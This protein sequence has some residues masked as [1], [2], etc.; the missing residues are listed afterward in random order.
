MSARRPASHRLGWALGAPL[1]VFL[2][3]PIAVL[4]LSSGPA[5]VWHALRQ[6]HALAAMGLSLWTTAVSLACIVAFG[7]PLAWAL[8][9]S[10][11]TA[12]RVVETIVELPI[13]VPPAVVGV[14]LLEAWGR[15]GAFGPL[16]EV[17][18][19]SL[20]FTTAAVVVAQV[21]VAAP[22]YVQAAASAFRRVDDDLILVARTLGAGPRRAFAQV[23]LPAAAP[24]LAAGAALAWA[25]A[26]GEFGATL[27]FAG[28][29]P[30]RTQTMPLAIYSALESDLAIARALA[31]VLALVAFAVLL[32]LRF[33]PGLRAAAGDTRS[34]P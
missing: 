24:G 14:G 33:A 30:G 31:L 23:V 29:L 7:T 21:V 32:T 6:P 18:G 3:I 11:R 15:R 16:L 2:A 13:V 27:F 20:S 22:F 4:A 26:L 10:R 25:R 9:R 34:R 5:E 19:V 1:A 8:A 12:A 28:S 17:L